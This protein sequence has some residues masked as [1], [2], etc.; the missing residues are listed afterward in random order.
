MEIRSFHPT[1]IS[2]V[3]S[4]ISAIMNKEYPVEEKA[5]Q[6]GDLNSI[7]DA[8]GALRE[9]FLVV[10]EDDEVIGTIGIKEDSDSTALLRRLF[11]HSSHRGRQIG[12]M[13]VDTA[14]DFC[15]M[16]GNPNVWKKS[17]KN[18]NRKTGMLPRYRKRRNAKKR[19]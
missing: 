9:K 12:S 17:N 3:K 14:L 1:D 18:G 15:K 2:C 4:L 10:Q 13:L 19:T 6:Y 7:S 11:V 8:Y 16:N 5:Y